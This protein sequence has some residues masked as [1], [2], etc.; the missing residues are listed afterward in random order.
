MRGECWD[1]GRRA[2]AIASALLLGAAPAAA[3]ASDRGPII[4]TVRGPA[5]GPA[6]WL[7]ED[8]DTRIYLFGL[9]HRLGTDVPWRSP[10]LDRAIGEADELVL[11]LEA[12]GASPAPT[13]SALLGEARP[14]AERV[15]PDRRE[16]LDRL[17]AATPFAPRAYDNLQSWAAAVMLL[18]FAPRDQAA[19]PAGGTISIENLLS[20]TF[21]NSGRA[22]TA[23]E[24]AER[25]LEIFSTLSA[26]DQQLLLEGVI[27][28]TVRGVRG[29]REDHRRWA[30]GDLAL[31]S[32]ASAPMPQP[33]YERVYAA[34]NRAWADWLERRLDEP[35]TVLFAVGAGHLAG[36]DSV[37]E[38]LERRGLAARRVQ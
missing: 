32:E 21:R 38:L 5:Q 37:Q 24:T 3:E 4:S 31:L 14:L 20:R 30:S 18:S 12:A 35:G 10:T 8:G 16:R 22:V 36:R 23:L 19:A 25:Q 15:S 9:L 34:R 17:I 26:A 13:A 7:V 29:S 1:L 6:V 2:A 27:D 11:E 28:G 33:I